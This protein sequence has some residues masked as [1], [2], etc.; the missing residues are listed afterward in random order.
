MICLNDIKCIRI[1]LVLN[2]KILYIQKPTYCKTRDVS[3]INSLIL[4]QPLNASGYAQVG[5]GKP[6][7]FLRCRSNDLHNDT[8]SW[9][10]YDLDAGTN[11]VMWRVPCG[12]GA[13]A[14]IVASV[15]FV[16]ALI[17]S[18]VIVSSSI[19]FSRKDNI[20]QL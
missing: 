13:V 8:C 9:A 12:N 1:V 6:D 7:L 15:T 2:K 20:K 10:I 17:C 16:S 19:C 18:L 4:M 14:G 11:N 5:I 3:H